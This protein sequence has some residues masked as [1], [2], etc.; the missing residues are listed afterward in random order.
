MA[1]RWPI[2]DDQIVTGLAT[3][4]LSGVKPHLAQHRVVQ[5]P[6]YSPQKCAHHISLEDLLVQKRRV[7]NH[8]AVFAQGG[9]GTHIDGPEVLGDWL[10]FGEVTTHAE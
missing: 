3:D 10:Y 1:R 7:Q 4:H 2:K 8:H 6:R 5:Q 9:L